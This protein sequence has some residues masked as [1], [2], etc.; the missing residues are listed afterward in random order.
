MN[1]EHCQKRP[2][3]ETYRYCANCLRWKKREMLQSG[4]LQEVPDDP[5]TYFGAVSELEDSRA[6][7]AEVLA[8]DHAR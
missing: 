5:V 8:S 6:L 1:C 7:A 4:Y 2:R 3:V